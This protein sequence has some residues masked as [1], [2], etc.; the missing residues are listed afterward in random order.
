MK[1][2]ENQCQVT[3][4]TPVGDV[5]AGSVTSA[6]GVE[7][8][9]DV[10]VPPVE[11]RAGSRV[12]PAEASGVTRYNTL[13]QAQAYVAADR[14]WWKSLMRP[15]FNERND[16]AHIALDV[17]RHKAFLAF[18]AG[19]ATARQLIADIEVHGELNQ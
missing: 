13:V 8:C 2:E 18:G 6:E 12:Q 7:K 5:E 10:P 1:Q 9:K 17:A 19:I 3:L 4:A 11:E 14:A 15:P 16:T